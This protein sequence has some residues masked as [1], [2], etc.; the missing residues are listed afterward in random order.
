MGRP[1]KYE[2]NVEPNLERI[3]SWARDGA[4][5]ER[6]AEKLGVA[7]S[8]FREYKGKY[9]ALSAVLKKGKDDY[10]DEVVDALHLNTTGGK[11]MLKRPF[12]CKVKK[13][14]EAGRLIEE[15]EEIVYADY[16]EYVKPDTM[17]QIYWLNNRRPEEWRQKREDRSMETTSELKAAVCKAEEEGKDGTD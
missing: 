6:I 1:S 7:Y 17:A 11:V 13:F 14:N 9:P 10:D 4:T 3:K 12:K 8:T 15:R 5:D 16:E 2:S